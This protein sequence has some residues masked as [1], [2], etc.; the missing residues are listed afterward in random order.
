MSKTLVEVHQQMFKKETDAT[1]SLI[2]SVDSR[3]RMKQL[4]DGKA[5]PLWLI[6]HLS[7]TN[8]L[9]VLKWCLEG[10]SLVD[11]ELIAKFS[12]DFSGGTA[13]TDD[14]SFYPSW[15][16]VGALYKSVASACVE[17]IGALSEELLLGPLRGNAP[18]AMQAMFGNV[19]DTIRA[20][21]GHNAYHRGQIG[22][23]NALD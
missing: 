13:P 4:Q 10:E 22:I 15:D 8:N 2:E 14:A 1:L 9:L 21:A 11:K 20:M 16:D 5:H 19:D 7:N 23:I 3:K 18:A 12:P 6:G 17:G